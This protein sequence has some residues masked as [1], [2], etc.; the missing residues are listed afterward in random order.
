MDS[1][2]IGGGDQKNHSARHALLRPVGSSVVTFRREITRPADT[3]AYTAGDAVGG[4]IALTGVTAP[5][6]CAFLLGASIQTDRSA[7]TA[8]YR[9]HFYSSAPVAFTDNNAVIAPRQAERESY[10]GNVTFPAMAGVGTGAEAFC[11]LAQTS[12]PFP[13]PLSG[14]DLYVVMEVTDADTPASEQKFAFTFI[15]DTNS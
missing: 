10:L 5:G 9:A 11:R 14:G 12:A 1:R 15:I 7:S 13:L 4:T 2:V 3:T 6:T 8:V